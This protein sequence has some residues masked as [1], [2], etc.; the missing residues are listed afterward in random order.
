MNRFFLFLLIALVAIVSPVSAQQH[1]NVEPTDSAHIFTLFG[2]LP[3]GEVAI[4]AN[5]GGWHLVVGSSICSDSIT[6]VES[7]PDNPNTERVEGFSNGQEFRAFGFD[8][9]IGLE[10]EIDHQTITQGNRRLTKNGETSITT[11]FENPRQWIIK[12]PEHWVDEKMGEANHSFVIMPDSLFAQN[13]LNN[14]DEIAIFTPNGYMA[15]SC[16]YH[17]LFD[18]H[19]RGWVGLAAWGDDPQTEIIDGFRDGESYQFKVW[20]HTEDQEIDIQYEIIRMDPTCDVWHDWGYTRVM[21]TLSEEELVLN[22]NTKPSAFQ[23]N[24]AYPNPFN[25]MTR[26]SFSQPSA[27]MMSL[28]VFNVEGREVRRL[29]NGSTTA[30]INSIIFDANGLP[31][32]AYFLRLTGPNGEVGQQKIVL[33]K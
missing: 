17:E 21:L 3:D 30:G 32:G 5:Q 9:V 20:H 2:N 25:S 33:G 8:Q 18:N 29:I 7:W 10:Y 26:I 13:N 23:L 27:G 31:T 4:G 12:N 15:G 11:D 6:I 14:F 28:N 19:G 16:T 1:W 22:P 24:P